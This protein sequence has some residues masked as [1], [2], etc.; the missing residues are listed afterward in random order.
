MEE[1]KT[2]YPWRLSLIVNFTSILLLII[3]FEILKKTGPDNWLVFLEILFLAIAIVSFM[4]A[5]VMTGLYKF[6]HRKYSTLD[7]REVQVVNKALRYSYSI[8]TI[9]VLVIIYVYA[10][11]ENGPIDVVIAAGLLYFAHMLPAGILGWN[12]KGNY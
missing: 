6:T 4:Y 9:L 1:N 7:E 10:I 12:Q 5:F 3:V 8:F 11:F 2:K